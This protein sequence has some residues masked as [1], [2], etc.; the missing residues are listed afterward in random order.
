MGMHI[1]SYQGYLSCANDCAKMNFFC[2]LS[3]PRPS[4]N[5]AGMRTTDIVNMQMCITLL[6]GVFQLSLLLRK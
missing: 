6:R 5:K 2:C 3:N 4:L 1:N